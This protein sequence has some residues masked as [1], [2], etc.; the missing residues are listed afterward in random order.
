MILFAFLGWPVI[1]AQQLGLLDDGW[2]RAMT[3]IIFGYFAF[4]IALTIP[5]F[6]WI[7]RLVRFQKKLARESQSRSNS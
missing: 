2:H 1:H 7:V 6:Y 5:V 4:S 3:V